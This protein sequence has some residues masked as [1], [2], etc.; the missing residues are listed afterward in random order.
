MISTATL[1][2]LA[3]LRT[4]VEKGRDYLDYLRPFI[5]Q[6][7]LDHN[8]D[9]VTTEKV[10]KYILKDFG[11]KIPNQTIEIV[12]K[13]ISKLHYLKRKDGVYQITKNLPD[14]NLVSE[15][16]D[17]KRHINAI[18]H[19]L[20]EFSQDTAKVINDPNDAVF[21]ICTFL[22]EFDI[23]CLR[24]YLHDNVIPDI[25]K[26]HKT[27]I[28]L[29]SDYVQY[30]L[31]TNPERFKSFL[32]LVQGHMMANALLCPDLKNIS[33]TFK[34]VTFYLD[35]PL[36]IRVLGL[37]GE[38]RR[39][40]S[41]ELVALINR[42]G[43][44][45][46]TFSHSYD[47]LRR[48]LQGAADHLN[49]SNSRGGIVLEARRLGKTRSDLLYL[50]PL[51]EEELNKAG[52]S[53][54][55]TPRYIENFQ[56]DETAFEKI[57]EDEINYFNPR[58]REYDI[59]SVRSIYT[60]RG[61]IFVPSLEKSKAVFVTSNT[62]F[63]K[64][65]YIYGQKHRAAR[66]VSVVI[67]DFTLANVAWLKAPMDAPSIPKA[68]LL[69]LSYAALKPSKP[70]LNKY[71]AEIDKL[72]KQGVITAVAHQVLRSN[73]MAYNELM[74]QT[75]GDDAAFNEE[76]I[77]Q[78][79][80]RL[81][82]EVQQEADMKLDTEKKAHIKTRTILESK[83]AYI[84]KIEQAKYSKCENQARFFTRLLSGFIILILLIALSSSLGLLS[85]IGLN[86]ASPFSWLI[87]GCSMVLLILTLLNLVSGSNVKT[88]RSQI[89]KWYLNRLLRRESK[90]IGVDLSKPDADK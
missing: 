79:L 29:V 31:R 35:T 76:T 4:K 18:I 87:G 1:T 74:H 40:A 11:L 23:T 72:E 20:Q 22:T 61:N 54:E 65:A 89:E 16:S 47:E 69:A 38:S 49:S 27:D 67:P 8:F 36:L 39:D 3:I 37:E 41:S 2:S 56:I 62:S 70:L 78:T 33:G 25:K 48:V 86:I 51:L 10:N 24:A 45:I 80:K 53:V 82:K 59:N 81:S 77:P 85:Y 44:K 84:Q 52:I 46:A 32:V 5:F 13:R 12:L 57:L 64:A 66:E 28:V 75:L 88:I 42:L 19:G 26:S 58:A 9:I 83:E 30:L 71:L 7:L 14:P 50:I 55:S 63:A 34:K 6:V 43:G 68:Q 90:S 60:I 17:A 15:M 73:E 21:A